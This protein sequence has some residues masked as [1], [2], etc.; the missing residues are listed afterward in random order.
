MQC[1]FRPA[2][3]AWAEQLAAVLLEQFEDAQA[4]GFFFTAHD[5][6]KLL[7]RP[8]PGH[9]SPMPSGNGAAARA[10]IRLAAVTGEARYLQA[11]ER[12]LRLFEAPMR[13]FPGGFGMLTLALGEALMPPAVLVLRGRPEAVTEAATRFAAAYLPDT[14]VLAIPDGVSGLPPTLDKPARGDPV[15]GWLCRGQHCLEPSSD[16]A[17]LLSLCRGSASRPKFP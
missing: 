12:A 3:L 11:A 10:L 4:G 6:E 15:T 9:D 2:D 13:Q 1:E 5:H 7:H 17:T 14:V 16:V 8:K